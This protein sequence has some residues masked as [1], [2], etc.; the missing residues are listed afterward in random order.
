MLV[1]LMILKIYTLASSVEVRNLSGNF[2]GFVPL[3]MQVRDA[4]ILLESEL[5]D[6]HYHF[7][8]LTSEGRLKNHEYIPDKPLTLIQHPKKPPIAF[9]GDIFVEIT[10]SPGGG[11][12]LQF[13]QEED[14][15]SYHETLQAEI[16]E[17]VQDLHVS[18][19]ILVVLKTDG[20]V[21]CFCDMIIGV[22]EK[23]IIE[24]Y[25]NIKQVITFAECGVVL[26]TFGGE[27]I[28]PKMTPMFAE[29]LKEK[30]KMTKKVERIF[31][32][33]ILTGDFVAIFDD[34]SNKLF[35]DGLED[36]THKTE[37]EK[38]IQMENM[39]L[40]ENQNGDC[41]IEFEL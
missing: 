21:I 5:N 18:R 40:V 9:D 33:P 23:D 25:E 19:D 35:V 30:E 11:V 28:M 34:G 38:L 20:I 24:R 41:N 29:F 14:R 31:G 4:K 1:L 8:L 7:S 37:I 22:P 26:L 10:F 16:E 3:G 32:L 27:I 6:K 39:K 13:H 2:I 12:D 36:N 17:D 15:E